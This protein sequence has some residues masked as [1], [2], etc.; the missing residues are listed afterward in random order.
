MRLAAATA[1]ARGA[2]GLTENVFRDTALAG[3]PVTDVITP[4]SLSSDLGWPVSASWRGSV[5]LVG[6]VTFPAGGGR[7]AIDC[8]FV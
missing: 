1:D 7:F 6:T 8:A 4:A 3:D 2:P 5:E